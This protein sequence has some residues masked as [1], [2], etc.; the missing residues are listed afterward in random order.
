[1]RA[2]LVPVAVLGAAAVAVVVLDP[3]HHDVP[4][5]PL[6]ATTGL[7]CPF[8]G[9]LRAVWLLAHLQVG[10]AMSS[11]LVLFALGPYLAWRWWRTVTARPPAVLR[12]GAT[13]VPQRYV[14]VA[15]VVLL[16]AYGVVRNLPVGGFLAPA[17]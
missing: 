13:V 3:V 16:V 10:A 8:C 14:T 1:M 4:L 7:W 12:L 15:V 2:A 11:N 17:G 9:G 5:C 6:H